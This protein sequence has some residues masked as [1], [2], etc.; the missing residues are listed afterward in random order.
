M[1]E[2]EWIGATAGNPESQKYVG[3]SRADALKAADTAGVKAVRVIE[4]S[5]H[6]TAD[7]RSDRLNI[8]VADGYVTKAAFF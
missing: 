1:K 6:L 2:R 3:L 8:L 5:Q 4:G 7:F